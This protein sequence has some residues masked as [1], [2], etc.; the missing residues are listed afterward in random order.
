MQELSN[1]R[2]TGCAI[3]LLEKVPDI[4]HLW[5]CSVLQGHGHPMTAADVTIES[6][7]RRSQRCIDQTTNQ[8]AWTRFVLTVTDR[9]AAQYLT[10]D[11]NR[12]CWAYAPNGSCRAN[13]QNLW[14]GRLNT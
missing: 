1:H 5:V 6:V 13:V 7:P 4:L 9:A 11:I 3:D 8:E 10:A 14:F 12:L 2:V